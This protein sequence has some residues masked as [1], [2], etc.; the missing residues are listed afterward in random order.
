MK[1]GTNK[2]RLRNN[3]ILFGYQEKTANKCTVMLYALKNLY[4]DNIGFTVESIR[5]NS[6]E[7]LKSKSYYQISLFP[8]PKFTYVFT[9][10]DQGAGVTEDGDTWY[11]GSFQ[12]DTN[13]ESWLEEVKG[14][15]D[16]YSRSYY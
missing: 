6:I 3:L 1:R 2:A 4:G 7:Q 15:A 10:F 5:Y 12:G 13:D 11:V 16:Y 9:V 14:A 8:Q